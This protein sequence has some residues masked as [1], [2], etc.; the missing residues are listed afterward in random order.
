MQQSLSYYQDLK[1]HCVKTLHHVSPFGTQEI[2]QAETM[3]HHH[4]L[5]VIIM[6]FDNC[7]LQ[8]MADAC[9][10]CKI[11]TNETCESLLPGQQNLIQIQSVPTN[12]KHPLSS[13]SPCSKCASTRSHRLSSSLGPAVGLNV[14]GI[15]KIMLTVLKL[16]FY[17]LLALTMQT[18][19]Q[20]IL[21]E[22]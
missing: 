15:R 13:F 9:N 10:R 17:Q 19:K 20:L 8:R 4:D 7:C 2:G 18:T 12:T 22:E 21:L 6:G 14:S 11:K 5:M 1:T 16:K 3:A